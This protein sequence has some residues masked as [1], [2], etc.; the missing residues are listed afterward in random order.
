MSYCNNG[1]E[2]QECEISSDLEHQ[3]TVYVLFID[4]PKE[5]K[6]LSYV[7]HKFVG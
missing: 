3:K 5:N 7:I 2:T 1:Y 6:F 4:R